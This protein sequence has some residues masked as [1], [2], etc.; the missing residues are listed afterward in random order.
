MDQPLWYKDATF[1]QVYVRAYKDSNGD[2]H[3]DLKGLTQK[4]DYLQELGVDC[5]WLMPLYP[6]PLRDDGYDIADYYN[7]AETFGTL[8]DFRALIDAAHARDIRIIMDLVLNH[9]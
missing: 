7:I 9:T 2:G 3:G 5:L 6:S 4:L 1:Y 8:D